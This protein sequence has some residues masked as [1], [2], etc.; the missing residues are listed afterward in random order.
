MKAACK[1]IH[2]ISTVF[3]KYFGRT[4]SIQIDGTC[5]IFMIFTRKDG[6]IPWLKNIHH[7]LVF[8][9]F[10]K[11]DFVW[12]TSVSTDSQTFFFIFGLVK[13]IWVCHLP[14]EQCSGARVWLLYIE[15]YTTHYG[16]CFLAIVR[17]RMNQSG[18]NG[19]SAKGFE[20]CSDGIVFNVRS[21]KGRWFLYG[22]NISTIRFLVGNGDCKL[23][24]GKELDKVIQ[25]RR[26]SYIIGSRPMV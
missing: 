15:D 14:D 25:M 9:C 24:H 13:R 11:T 2:W 23:W 4:Q 26:V 8:Q 12:T 19:M 7:P 18:F 21:P 16:D 5:T 10:G 17:I 6:D 1:L 3:F 22:A 20:R